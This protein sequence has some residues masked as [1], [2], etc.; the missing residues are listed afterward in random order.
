VFNEK[1]MQGPAL[2]VCAILSTLFAALHLIT[3][4]LRD[5]TLA[6]VIFLSAGI[7]LVSSLGLGVWTI[8]LASLVEESLT[9]ASVQP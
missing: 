4:L 2:A 1:D 6:Y 7:C 9:R 5:F 8:T 3:S